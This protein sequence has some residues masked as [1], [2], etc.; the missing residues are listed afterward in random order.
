MKPVRQKDIKELP[1]K[2]LDMRACI[3][4]AIIGFLWGAVVAFV[5]IGFS[6]TYFVFSV[7]SLPVP[8]S[9]SNFFIGFQIFVFLIDGFI[10][11]VI[12]Y[13][14]L[15]TLLREYDKRLYMKYMQEGRIK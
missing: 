11:F 5:A 13:F 2:W 6:I 7:L 12:V 10:V 4:A 1:S 14:L 15:W 3:P 8:M 9:F